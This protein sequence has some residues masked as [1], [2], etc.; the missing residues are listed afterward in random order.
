MQKVTILRPL[1]SSHSDV[2]TLYLF[3]NH[4]G[5]MA[6]RLAYRLN[7]ELP[8][9]CIPI[10]LAKNDSNIE[11]YKVLNN[12]AYDLSALEKP[13]GLYSVLVETNEREDDIYFHGGME[14]S[15]TFQTF[16][17]RALSMVLVVIE[18]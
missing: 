12:S 14:E 9:N 4:E 15:A 2:G 8:R 13:N 3:Y 1:P 5:T 17:I 11:I 18:L 7:F 10:A 6:N 16:E